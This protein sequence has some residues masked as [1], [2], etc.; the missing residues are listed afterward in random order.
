MF[1][2]DI[3][4][5]RTTRKDILK[6]HMNTNH[7]HEH[8]K[9]KCKVCCKIFLNIAGLKVHMVTHIRKKIK[10]PL[11][12]IKLGT[13]SV[14]REHIESIHYSSDKSSIACLCD[15]CGVNYYS[16]LYLDIHMKKVHSHPFKCHDRVCKKSF[17]S[18]Q[19]RKIHYL[20][21]HNSDKKVS[22]ILI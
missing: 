13:Y 5:Y 17:R 9:L 6:S 19:Q 3:C 14:Y 8:L 4:D 12:K 22:Q 2:C 18:I 1:F 10:C 7:T 16:K 15:I 21:W 20:S 11:C